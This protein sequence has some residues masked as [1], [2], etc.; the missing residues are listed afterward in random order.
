MLGVVQ[1]KGR[2]YTG[3]GVVIII[4]CGLFFSSHFLIARVRVL[5]LCILKYLQERSGSDCLWFGSGW[6]K[7]L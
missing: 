7:K 5:P 6:V 2:D 4:F 3:F 1:Y